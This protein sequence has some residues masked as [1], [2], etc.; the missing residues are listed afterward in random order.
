MTPGSG[1]LGQNQ[2]FFVAPT[3]GALGRIVSS[4]SSGS[5]LAAG[6]PGV[7]GKPQ[8]I[9]MAT[10]HA[11]SPGTPFGQHM[12]L[13]QLSPSGPHSANSG[14]SGGQHQ[15]VKKIVGTPDYLAPESILGIGM[16]D[17]AVDWWALGVILYE[18]LY[19]YPPFHAETPNLVFD[20]ILSRNIDWEEDTMDI[21]P[22]ARDLMERLMCTDPKERLG[23]R[24]MEEIKAHPFFE[25]ID[26]Q[27]IVS[28]EGPFVPQIS[29]PESTDYFDL[30]GA[31]QQDF[32]HEFAAT[33]PSVTAF[34]QAIENKRLLEPNRTPS[35]L[36]IR[37]R[38]DRTRTE[39]VVEQSMTDDFGSFSYKNLSVLKQANDEVIRKMRDEQQLSQ[40]LAAQQKEEHHAHQQHQPVQQGQHGQSSSA[41]ALQSRN[42]SL[43]AKL[44]AA[45]AARAGFSQAQVARPPSPAL[46][47]STQSSGQL[48]TRQPTSPAPISLSASSSLRHKPRASDMS[49]GSGSGSG[50]GSP[51]GTGTFVTTVMERKRSQLAEDDAQNMMRKTSLPSRLR[52]ASLSTTEHRSS[53]YSS[54]LGSSGSWKPRHSLVDEN[55]EQLLLGDGGPASAPTA[56]D[57]SVLA[58]EVV[59]AVPECLVAE[60][61][62]ISQRM[63]C[64]VLGKMGCKCTTVRNGADAVRLAMADTIYAVLFID[65]TLPIVNGSDVARMIKS[66]R[67][68]NSQ[69]P[70]LALTPY[71]K[72]EPLDVTGSVFD[73]CITKPVDTAEV[74]AL[75]PAILT[76]HALLVSGALSG[77]GASGAEILPGA[78]SFSGARQRAR[79]SQGGLGR[80]RMWQKVRS[81]SG[82]TNIS[83]PGS[84]SDGIPLGGYFD[85]KQ[86]ALL[87][88]TEGEEDEQDEVEKDEDALATK[89]STI[90]LAADGGRGRKES[91]DEDAAQGP[92][93]KEATPQL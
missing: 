84:G 85:D 49:S 57:G 2:A 75:M 36:T 45:N 11:E 6:T 13:D 92:E 37:N 20:N 8:P 87:T 21:S 29:D 90:T 31:M 70:I 3:H 34:A 5:D 25:G 78:G 28:K 1:G 80:P 16:D 77:A 17:K 10:A 58:K 60:D 41:A 48:R 44:A 50:S 7:M 88:D 19:G 15:Q 65:L 24:G 26:W 4:E 72:E 52:T 79:T 23:S 59:P 73:G 40:Q 18:F 82:R 56:A 62:P 81:V 63:L 71:D 22:A 43:S 61:N 53:A 39:R 54:H 55:A 68:V 91:R 32:V 47:V 89:L 51:A 12:L 38:L 93:D 86:S 27:D 42:R 74:R 46:S 69:T 83:T 76:H 30:R 66:T 64:Q 67:N 33:A 35:R 9:A 14:G